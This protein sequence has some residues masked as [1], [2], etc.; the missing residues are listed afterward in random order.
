MV[1]K[2][3]TKE[4]AVGPSEVSIILKTPGEEENNPITKPKQE[5]GPPTPS[6]ELILCATCLKAKASACS[7]FRKFAVFLS[8]ELSGAAVQQMKG[9]TKWLH[10]N[11][12][13]FRARALL[14]A[15][16][17]AGLGTLRSC[18]VP[19]VHAREPGERWRS[20]RRASFHRFCCS[21]DRYSQGF[22][23]QQPALLLGR[24]QNTEQLKYRSGFPCS[25][26]R[27]QGNKGRPPS[28]LIY[29]EKSCSRDPL[30]QQQPGHPLPREQRCSP[31]PQPTAFNWEHEL[32]RGRKVVKRQGQTARGWRRGARDQ[33][34]EAGT[35]DMSS[36]QHEQAP[37]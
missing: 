23:P 8:K 37:G 29:I 3:A 11:L 17:A 36:L 9:H 10:H 30:L 35:W 2:R 22:P 16:A 31:Q 27:G 6:K 15:R 24:S 25:N 12:P 33:R 5:P 28:P 34:E 19:E 32:G 20:R 26:R 7:P 13:V 4:R 18:V 21:P 14:Q 1:L